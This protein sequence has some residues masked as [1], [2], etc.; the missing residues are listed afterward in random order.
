MAE[1][2]EQRITQLE[3]IVNELTA[4]VAADPENM[5]LPPLLAAAKAELLDL[6]AAE[7][8]AAEKAAAEVAAAEVA[9]AEKAAAEVAAAEAK[10]VADAKA[11]A[12]AAPAATPA[13]ARATSFR[14]A[15]IAIKP[16]PPTVPE[17]MK[18]GARPSPAARRPAPVAGT[19]RSGH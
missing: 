4:R 19:S 10:A 12:A 8:A 6:Q 9:A 18:A 17:S 2:N 7:V 13:P 14:T 5:D 11:A 1:T 16:L 15:A 3:S